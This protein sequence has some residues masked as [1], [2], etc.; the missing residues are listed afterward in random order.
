[1]QVQQTR[2]LPDLDPVGPFQA[3]RLLRCP[4]GICLLGREPY[5]A[6][7][8]VDD[9]PLNTIRATTPSHYLEM[10][11]EGRSFG[12]FGPKPGSE[13]SRLRK[14]HLR[15]AGRPTEDAAPGNLANSVSSERTV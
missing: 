8:K 5:A 6:V 9:R 7:R 2:I 4:A 12:G 15:G 14:L 11:V 13:S 10:P 3:W 1:M